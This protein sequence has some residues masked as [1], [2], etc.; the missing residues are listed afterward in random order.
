MTNVLLIWDYDTPITRVTTT[1][2][3]NCNFDQWLQE[4]HHVKYIL[5]AAKTLNAKFTFAVVGFGAEVSVAPFDVRHIIKQIHTE[6]H[7]IA[8]HSWKHEWLPHLS[9]FQLDK[10]IERSKWILEQCL[11]NNHIVNGFVLPHDRPM[12]W[13]SKLAFSIGDRS[14]YLFF[15]GADIDGVAKSLKKHN[16]KWLRYNTRPVTQ[17]LK[18]WNGTD[19]KLKL[20]KKFISQGSF[21]FIPEHCME[22]GERTIEALNWSVANDKTLVIAAHPAALG[23]KQKYL[24]EFNRFLDLSTQ[25]QQEGK[26]NFITVSDHLNLSTNA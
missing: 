20:N 19:L 7:E 4:E 10:T 15:S 24:D 2:P 12:S 26:I 17:K 8:S 3:Y 1:N 9:Q 5:E 25:L 13:R 22:F 18:D 23:F 21:H 16:Y 11:D 14:L 6:G